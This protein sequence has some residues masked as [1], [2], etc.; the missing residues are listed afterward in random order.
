MKRK[1]IKYSLLVLAT[2]L[3]GCSSF[4]KK[5]KKI[6]TV[7]IEP[8][9]YFTEQ[10]AGDKYKVETMV[11]HGNNDESYDPIP[12]QLV[13]LDKSEA[14]LRIGDIGFERIWMNR[15]MTNAPHLL[16]FNTATG[17]KLMPNKD[18][19]IW[20]SPQ[21]VLV[22]SDNICRALCN[23]DKNNETFYI[24][25]V[26][27]FKK[28][29]F[30]LNDS[31]KYLLKDANKA[32]VIYH[33]TLTYFARDY[34]LT[35]ITIEENGKTPSPQQL[36][37]IIQKAKAMKVKVVFVQKEF[38]EHNAQLVANSIGAK[39]VIIDPLSYD[40]DRQIIKVARTLK[41]N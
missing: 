41:N 6:I 21:N 9:R 12:S 2:L 16:V 38:D 10:I 8:Q 3:C 28:Q 11:P 15:L 18:P 22:I 39:I 17:L 13:S 31:I 24:E 32:F 37:V 14:Y 19:H 36:Q 7:T 33:P 25:R 40:W 26:Q 23:L 5:N 1:I 34:G 27:K 35:Q 4:E 29:L 30:K 20:E